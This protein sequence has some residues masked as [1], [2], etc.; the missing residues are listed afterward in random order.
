MFDKI[1]ELL[2]DYT[3]FDASK[4]TRDTNLIMDLELTSLDVVKLVLDFEDEFDIEIPE[5][6]IETLT[7]IGDLEDC[8]KNLM[9]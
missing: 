5:E 9:D 4:M 7:T 8:I 2:A 6:E 3:E 1:V